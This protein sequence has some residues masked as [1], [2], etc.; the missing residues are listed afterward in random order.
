[1]EGESIGGVE[2]LTR[3]FFSVRSTA[4][5]EH[6]REGCVYLLG[7]LGGFMQLW[8]QCNGSLDLV[9]PW[10]RRI[11][12]YRLGPRGLIAF[13]SDFD[14]DER[15]AI[16]VYDGVRITRVAGGDG[17]VNMLGAWGPGGLAYTSNSRNGVDFD[18]YIWEPG[19]GSRLVAR[20]EG[21]NYAAEWARE[22]LVVV[23]RN[24]NLDSDIW[25]F[26]PSTGEGVNLTSHR[27]EAL[28]VSPSYLGNGRLA[29]ATS[30]D[31][32]FLSLAVYDL[33]ARTWRIVAE[34]GWDVELVEAGDK[35]YYTV[36]EDG[37]SI[38]YTWTPG[39][40]ARPYWRAPG[41]VTWLDWGEGLLASVSSPVAGN[42]VFRLRRMLGERITRSPKAGIR[43]EDL[44]YP[45][46]FEYESFDGLKVRGILYTPSKPASTP[47][48]A[49]VWLHGGPESQER[50]RFNQFHQLFQSLGVAVVAPNFR[51][52][53]GYGKR[54]VHLD[55]VDKREGAVHDVYHAVEALTS[56]GLIDRRRLCVMG[57]SY[58]GYLTLMSM[59][60]YPELWRCGV[61]IVGI[62]NLVTFIRNTSPYRR[63][64]R[65]AE[66]GDPDRDGE[67]MLKLSPISHVHKIKAPLMIVHGARDPRVPVS[68]AEQLVEA[69]KGRGVEVEYIR[70][71][72]EGHGIAKIENR[73]RVYTKAA[74]FV[75]RH[76]GVEY[77]GEEP[78]GGSNT[79]HNPHSSGD[80]SRV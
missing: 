23:R 44:A 76:L 64:Y 2:L 51:G 31:R 1:M 11:G 27:G 62:V 3:R 4:Q 38:V 13:T 79:L 47:P 66:Y 42:E 60:L 43:E 30:I 10:E 36:N 59:A 14:G 65:M 50:V 75:L 25:L 5:A 61:E 9:F 15:W 68:E 21:I 46:K 26:N 33:E 24:S 34:H 32:E 37:E 70:L 78:S 39:E 20:L 77:G 40:G 16:Y 17:S 72:D 35:V 48:P 54:F 74:L 8:R 56:R 55:D 19:R 57:G 49:V 63:K 80:N 71:E 69:L 58:G 28:N 12:D 18:L 6:G 29:F 45:D 22:G 41:T 53:L 7:D 52:S 73:V 67:V